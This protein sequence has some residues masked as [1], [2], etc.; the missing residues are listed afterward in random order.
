[1]YS[2]VIRL[3]LGLTLE[4][5][6]HGM[7]LTCEF[8]CVCANEYPIAAWAPKYMSRNNNWP[9]RLVGMVEAF[10]LLAGLEITS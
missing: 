9:W 4:G 6:C 10:F 7:N 1:M 5:R 2:P 8:P 3:F